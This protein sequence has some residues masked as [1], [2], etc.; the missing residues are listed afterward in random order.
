[1]QCSNLDFDRTS[2][3]ENIQH[4]ELGVRLYPQSQGFFI[5]PICQCSF[6]VSRSTE[7]FLAETENN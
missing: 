7:E 2:Y 6:E 3:G 4:V 5:S 1:M